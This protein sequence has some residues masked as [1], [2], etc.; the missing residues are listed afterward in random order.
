MTRFGLIQIRKIGKFT[1]SETW[2]P[3]HPREICLFPRFPKV[4]PY[5]MT[6]YGVNACELITQ[7]PDMACVIKV[8]SLLQPWIKN[9]SNHKKLWRKLYSQNA[10]ESNLATIF[11]TKIA[12][13]STEEPFTKI[14]FDDETILNLKTKNL[15]Y[16]YM[17]YCIIRELAERNMAAL[18]FEDAKV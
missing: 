4:M 13:N 14:T 9:S 11:T 6:F 5:N 16:D 10:Q 3:L 15:D 2:R 17:A 1:E 18:E 8:E 7:N 12:H